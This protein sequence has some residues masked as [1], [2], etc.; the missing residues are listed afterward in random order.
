MEGLILVG[1]V[2]YGIAVLFSHMPRHIKEQIRDAQYMIYGITLS[3]AL[4]GL[5]WNLIAFI[6]HLITG[7]SFPMV[8]STSSM[9]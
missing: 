6:L 4:L 8:T 2:A 5:G 9:E 1:V 7:D 3:I